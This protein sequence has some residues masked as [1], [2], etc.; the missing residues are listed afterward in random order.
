MKPLCG[1][2]TG[3]NLAQLCRKGYMKTLSAN[4]LYYEPIL[5][6]AALYARFGTHP[7]ESGE[8]IDAIREY[9]S[10]I[11][12]LNHVQK[13]TAV[14]LI[15]LAPHTHWRSALPVIYTKHGDCYFVGPRQPKKSSN[16]LPVSFLVNNEKTLLPY[17]WLDLS[18]Q[19]IDLADAIACLDLINFLSQS[20]KYQNWP[21]SIGINFRF[22]TLCSKDIHP[23]IENPYEGNILGY[24]NP[25]KIELLTLQSVVTE[26]KASEQVSWALCFP[27]DEILSRDEQCIIDLI[28]S[29][30]ITAKSLA[31]YISKEVT[32]SF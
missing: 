26:N 29:S 12:D 16:Y 9:R 2:M 31:S 13:K 21:L 28:R 10:I 24:K 6:A 14:S 32:V 3:V 23:S 5:A 25:S 17:E 7:S 11:K 27:N 19:K 30:D 4:G 18:S 22:R 8:N 15:I 20:F 1:V